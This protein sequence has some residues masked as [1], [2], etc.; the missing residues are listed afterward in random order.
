MENNELI[1]LEVLNIASSSKEANAYAL[2]LGEVGGERHLPVII[3]ASEAQGI[4]LAIKELPTPRPFTHE[5]FAAFLVETGYA[6]Q[7]AIIYKE[8]EGIY[9]THLYFRGKNGDEITLEARPSDAVTLSLRCDARAKDI[10]NKNAVNFRRERKSPF[11]DLEL[12]DAEEL[13][14]QLADAIAKEDYE[15]AAVLRDKLR[16]MGEG[17]ENQSQFK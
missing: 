11:L 4:A 7:K 10:M 15:H 3:G 14:H 8:L 1:A 2:I 9:Y 5:L 6:L 12:E 13:R 16:T 17:E